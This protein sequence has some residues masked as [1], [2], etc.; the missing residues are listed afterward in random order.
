MR[1]KTIFSACSFSFCLALL[2][3]ISSLQVNAQRVSLT[4]NFKTFGVQKV[5]GLSGTNFKYE[6]ETAFSANLRFFDNNLWAFRIGI[7]SDKVSYKINDGFDTSY[8][9]DHS[10]FTTYLGLEKHLNAGWLTPYLGV[11][12]PITFNGNDDITDNSTGLVEQIDNGN[13][14]TGFSV[15]AGGNIKLFRIFRLGIEGNVGFDQFKEEVIKPIGNDNSSVKW[16]NLDYNTEVTLG[17]AF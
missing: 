6:G 12:V 16:K 10:S 5:E 4:G 8:N 15:L 9:I 13:I 11:Y 17:I 14:K 3:V 7:G 2:L 1:T